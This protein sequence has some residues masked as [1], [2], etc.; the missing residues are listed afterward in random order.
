MGTDQRTLNLSRQSKLVPEAAL[1]TWNF[2]IFGVGSVGSHV[3]HVLAKTG[4]QNLTVYDNDTVDK[5]NIGPQA[6]HFAHLKMNK[7]DAVKSLLNLV[8]SLTVILSR[9]LPL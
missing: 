8:C 4:F 2:H 5:E 3:A 6:F 1:S 7:V 9:S